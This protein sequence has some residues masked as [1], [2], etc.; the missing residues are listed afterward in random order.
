MGLNGLRRAIHWG[1]LL[2]FTGGGLM[3]ICGGCG[4]SKD[5]GG[6]TTLSS[7]T[8]NDPSALRPPI[9][10]PASRRGTLYER[11]G[12]EAVVRAVVEDFVSRVATDPTVKF[13]RQGQP[14]AWE[15]TPDNVERLK[16][17]LVEFVTTIA[18]GPLQY[19]GADMVTAHRGMAITNPEF[20]ALA[21]HLRA[22]LEANGVSRRE[23][24]ELLSAVGSMRGAVVEVADAP[25][26][27]APVPDDPAPTDAAAP[28][29]EPAPV[30]SV[31]PDPATSDPAPE[32]K[33][34]DPAPDR[35]PEQPGPE[36]AP[37][38]APD[39]APDPDSPALA[40]QPDQP[41]SDGASEVAP[42]PDAPS[43]S[44]PRG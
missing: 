37:V 17:R 33:S 24:D 3:P 15:A 1:T 12:G 35:S 32:T 25:P 30:D 6:S 39:G 5:A 2:L 44:D 43:P 9:R 16:Q 40:D 23:R 22:A 13:T 10:P 31:P 20:D 36:P 19:R 28:Q 26:A 7:A 21:G 18:G 38:P 41:R 27:T 4:T 29:P 14:T 34:E 11:M 8:Q 42:Q